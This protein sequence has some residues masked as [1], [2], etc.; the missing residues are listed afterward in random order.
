LQIHGVAG[1]NDL[2]WNDLAWN[3]LARNNLV[4]RVPNR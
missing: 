2:A 3:D 1:R 4:R